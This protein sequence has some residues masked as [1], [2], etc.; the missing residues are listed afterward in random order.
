MRTR[1]G[2]GPGE[3]APLGRPAM[4]HAVF[5]VALAG[6]AAAWPASASAASYAVIGA[7]PAAAQIGAISGTTLYGTLS[8]QGDGILF[9]M[10]LTG[11]YT[12]LHAFDSATDGSAPNA[13]LALDQA[14]TLYGTARDGGAN[15]AGTL[16]AFSPKGTMR[17]PH[18]FGSGGDG[19]VPMQGPT[20]GMHGAILGATGEGAIGGSGNLFTLSHK[21]AY[22]VL[23]EF[24][25]GSDGHCP[26]SGVAVARDGTIYGTTVGV[27]FGGNPTGSVWKYSTEGMLTTLYVFQ[28]GADGEWPDQA[29]ALDGSGNLY[30]TTHVQKGDSFAGAIWKITPEGQFSVLH[31]MNGTTDGYGPNAPLLSDGKG[32]LYGTAYGGGTAG[33][34]T[35][36][37]VTRAG[38]FT[39]LHNF[40]GG[41]DGAQ[42][43]GNLVRASNGVVYG[44]TSNGAIF[45]ITP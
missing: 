6:T 17:T 35:V 18:A 37:S 28:D 42:P 30:G 3:A 44:G 8:S 45:E 24:Q 13:R 12:Q 10:T 20:L 38:V 4:A 41:A 27:G 16:W 5:W 39:V 14:G 36:F 26:F 29:P 31:Q 19:A 25:S 7:A 1:N 23:Y 34:G 43:T 15:D 22:G 2:S 9:S 40:L 11:A 33:Y 32:T 21:G